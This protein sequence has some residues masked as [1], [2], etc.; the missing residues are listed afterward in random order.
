MTRNN[1]DFHGYTLEFEHANTSPVEDCDHHRVD[2]FSKDDEHIGSLIWFTHDAG[3]RNPGAIDVDVDPDHRR[4]GV[5][6]AMYKFALQK[7]DEH[8]IV[9]PDL[10]RSSYGPQG[11]KWARSLGLPKKFGEKE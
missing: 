3:A 7:A 1:A 4:K 6:T 10:L 2:A 8:N 9:K 5:A 11:Y